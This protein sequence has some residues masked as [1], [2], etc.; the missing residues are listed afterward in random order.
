[1]A[2]IAVIADYYYLEAFA[3]AYPKA[4][5]LKIILI[6]FSPSRKMIN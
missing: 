2:P 1:M 6:N 4:L 3:P 5:P